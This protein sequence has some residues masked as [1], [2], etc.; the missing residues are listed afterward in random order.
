MNGKGGRMQ[1]D[2]QKIESQVFNKKS[3]G[4]IPFRQGI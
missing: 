2:S 4:L 3:R 1:I